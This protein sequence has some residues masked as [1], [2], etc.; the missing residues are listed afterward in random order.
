M[1]N[2]PAISTRIHDRLFD[3]LARRTLLFN[4]CWEDP[5]VDHRALRIGPG[6][7]VLA[8]TSAGCNVLDYALAGP[9]AIHA[10]DANPRQTALLELKIAGIRALDHPTFFAVFGEGRCPGFREIYRDRLRPGLSPYAREFWDGR[11]R[12][13][14]GR[15]GRDSFYWHGLSGLFA[16]LVR[17]YSLTRPG[18]RRGLEALLDAPDLDAQW[19]IF[20]DEVEPRIWSR[21]MEW[22]LGT[23]LVLSLLGV[24][25]D[26]RAVI[27]AERPGGIAAHVRDALRRVFREV[28]AGTNYFW[29]VYIRGRYTPSC[30]P[31]YLRPEGFA[32]LKGGLV[33]RILPRT[34]TVS[35]FL[36]STGERLTR[37]VLLDHMDWMASRAPEALR[38]EWELI[39]ERAA[40]GARIIFRSGAVRPA[41]LEEVRVARPG[42]A[43]RGL[44]EHLVFDGALAGELQ[45]FDR[46]GTYGSFHIAEVRAA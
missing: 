1:G 34:C 14:E 6:D 25:A 41:F 42:E 11:C 27:E 31:G 10:V 39:L 22:A 17:I 15:K 40:P 26:Q 13:F 35:E 24:P 12:W 30:C 43:P 5:A 16:R 3:L 37:L 46:V 8:I 4:A 28:P 9:R 45:R 33:D 23:G 38:E 21:G 36:R 32:L 19:R 44:R 18:L 2:R 20:R 29:S 7:T